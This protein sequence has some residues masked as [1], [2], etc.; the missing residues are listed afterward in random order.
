MMPAP[1]RIGTLGDFHVRLQVFVRVC[2]QLCL[3]KKKACVLP[4]VSPHVPSKRWLFATSFWSV[5][6]TNSFDIFYT[7]VR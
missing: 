4:R 2:V 5:S 6:R 7:V 1:F 3:Q